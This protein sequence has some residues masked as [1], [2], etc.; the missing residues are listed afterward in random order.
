MTTGNAGYSVSET[1][2]QSKDPASVG[3]ERG[4]FTEDGLSCTHLDDNLQYIHTYV[5]EI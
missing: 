3:S 5:N 2:P 4:R 1:E